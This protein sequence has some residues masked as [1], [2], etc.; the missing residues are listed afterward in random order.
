VSYTSAVQQATALSHDAAGYLSRA[1]SSAQLSVAGASPKAPQSQ[2][3]PLPPLQR[4]ALPPGSLRLAREGAAGPYVP[5]W[6]RGATALASPRGSAALRAV[7]ELSGRSSTRRQ[8]FERS[9]DEHSSGAEEASDEESSSS[10]DDAERRRPPAAR[11]APAPLH[12]PAARSSDSDSDGGAGGEAPLRAAST[13]RYARSLSSRAAAHLRA[14]ARGALRSPFVTSAKL[15]EGN[16]PA[17]WL[18]F[19]LDVF[20]AVLASM[21]SLF[22][23]Q[24]CPPTRRRQLPGPLPFYVAASAQSHLCSLA[25]QLDWRRFSA[26]HAAVFVL[27]WATLLAFALAE[28]V[29]LWRE[30]AIMDLC[31]EDRT[32]AWGALSSQLAAFP[33]LALRM[34]RLNGCALLAATG[35]AV[36][37]ACNW[38]ASSALA[39]HEQYAEYRTPV[40]LLA[41]VTPAAR[42]LC[43]FWVVARD[44]RDLRLA[45]PLWGHGLVS[46]NCVDERFARTGEEDADAKV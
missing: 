6:P 22:V 2:R 43:G 42:R 26:L 15:S 40:L 10:A 34:D 39:L 45:L 4:A 11:P 24:L 31:D 5:P 37:L 7:K 19:L 30:L 46:L 14:S 36:L 13:L 25:E 12:R 33:R 41:L 18:S 29:F 8:P 23:P 21:L 9:E 44:S 28:A 32:A 16:S 3:A 1:L 20:C 17:R 38:G 27:N 35:L